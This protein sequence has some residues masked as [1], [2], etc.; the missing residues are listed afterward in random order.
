MQENHLSNYIVRTI[1]QENPLAYTERE[2]LLSDFT[3]TKVHFSPFAIGANTNASKRESVRESEVACFN[4]DRF[5]RTLQ[6]SQ[7]T[8]QSTN[9][10][11]EI[12]IQQT[13]YFSN[14]KPGLNRKAFNRVENAAIH[15]T[16]SVKTSNER[17][18][19]YSFPG[20]KFPRRRLAISRDLRNALRRADSIKTNDRPES[21]VVNVGNLIKYRE[22]KSNR[23]LAIGHVNGL[24]GFFASKTASKFFVARSQKSTN[25]FT[26]IRKVTLKASK[27]S[28]KGVNQ[29]SQRAKIYRD[30]TASVDAAKLL[31]VDGAVSEKTRSKFRV[32]KSRKRNEGAPSAVALRSSEHARSSK[33]GRNA[34]AWSTGLQPVASSIQQT[35]QALSL[36]A[37]APVHVYRINGLSLARF[38][39]DRE[40]LNQIKSLKAFIEAKKQTVALSGTGEK[41]V[42]KAKVNAWETGPKKS[43]RFLENL[44][45]ERVSRFQYAAVH[46]RDLVRFSFLSRY[47]KKASFLVSFFAYVLSILPRNRKETQLLRFLRK[48]VKVFAAQRKEILGVRL[49]LQGRINRWRR[50]KHIVGEKGRLSVYTYN[51]RREYGTAQAITRKGAVGLRLWLCYNPTFAKTYRQH[52]LA[53]VRRSL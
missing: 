11:A 27:S 30:K 5:F 51:S 22:G 28:R 12:R 14:Q 38:G 19:S 17:T 46:I 53:Y 41:F 44:E 32:S 31:S 45:R 23:A 3:S 7:T 26:K 9:A 42:Q 29:A 37:G 33:S 16:N 34:S 8:R 49:R 36:I 10:S 52:L 24:G 40:A 47:L 21:P 39:F 18:Q 4:V 2:W 43:S 6:R 15:S 13:N 25:R 48:I 1:S 50:T 20:A 35:R